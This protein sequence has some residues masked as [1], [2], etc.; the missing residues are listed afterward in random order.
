MQIKFE[1][2]DGTQKL[3][4]DVTEVNGNLI[5]DTFSNTIEVFQG[6]KKTKIKQ[7]EVD[8]FKISK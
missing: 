1:M 3:F 7:S 6:K 5:F 4:E 2:T 8:R